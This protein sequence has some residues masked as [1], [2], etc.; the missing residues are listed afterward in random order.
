MIAQSVRRGLFAAL[1]LHS[2]TPVLHAQATATPQT[3]ATEPALA[4]H[5]VS[6]WGVEGRAWPDLA[7]RRWFDRFPALA[8]STVTPAVW[9]LSRHSAGMMVRF[10]TNAEVIWAT[11][12]LL[13]ERLALPNMTAIGASGLDLY[14]RDD[15]GKWR[16]A[17]ALGPNAKV[18]RQAVRVCALSAVVQR[19]RQP[20]HRRTNDGHVR[21]A[22]SAQRLADR[23]LR[24]LNYARCERIAARHGTC[25]HSRP[26]V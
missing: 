6:Q 17:G 25:R 23:V 26:P 18:V 14:A 12:T 16:W 1:A 2:G 5:E 24:D 21:T 13:H 7:R 20:V 19:P 22:R 9:D 4:W 11:Y 8:Q 10:R 15:A 3:Q